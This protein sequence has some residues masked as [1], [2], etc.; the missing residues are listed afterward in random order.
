MLHVYTAKEPTEGRANHEHECP[1]ARLWKLVIIIREN[2]SAKAKLTPAP[3]PTRKDTQIVRID[4]RMNITCT[5]LQFLVYL[6]IISLIT[7]KS[8]QTITDNQSS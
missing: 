6:I 7:H 4:G 3:K 5:I 1:K 2:A 8:S